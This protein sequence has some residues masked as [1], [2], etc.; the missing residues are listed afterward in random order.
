MESKHPEP[1]GGL[2]S[3]AYSRISAGNFVEPSAKLVKSLLRIL[4][5]G[6]GVALTTID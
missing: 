6:G 4:K 1:G 5:K 3:R 2:R